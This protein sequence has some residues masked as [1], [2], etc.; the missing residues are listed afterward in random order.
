MINIIIFFRQEIYFERRGQR[1]CPKGKL[2]AKY[3]NKL[4]SLKN[5]R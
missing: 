2:Y 1:K 4:R 5:H 3:F